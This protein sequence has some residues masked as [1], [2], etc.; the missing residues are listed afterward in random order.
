MRTLVL[1][2][3]GG[4]SISSGLGTEWR[5]Q[6]AKTFLWGLQA[7]RIAPWPVPVSLGP[8]LLLN[9]TCHGK[10]ISGPHFPG[11]DV[12]QVDKIHRLPD[13]GPVDPSPLL[14]RLGFLY[15]TAAQFVPEFTHVP[16]WFQFHSAARGPTGLLLWSLDRPL[17]TAAWVHSAPGAGGRRVLGPLAGQ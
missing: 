12:S 4:G 11:A 5:L 9:S 2:G 16:R 13:H 10:S 14:L 6:T 17:L 1:G 7:P 15:H 3:S 8:H